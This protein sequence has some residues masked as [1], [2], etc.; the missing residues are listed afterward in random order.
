MKNRPVW[1]FLLLAYAISWGLNEIG[2]Q[3]L[4]EGTVWGS[5]L[6]G[7]VFMWGPAVAVFIL[8]PRLA[9]TWKEL[10]VVK[11][12][13]HW[14]W[15]GVAALLAMA[16]P[17][18]TLLFNWLLGDLLGLPGFGHTAVTK[19]M[20]L[21]IMEDRLAAT[22]WTPDRIQNG[23]DPLASLPLNGP[24][25]LLLA[26]LTGVLAGGTVNLAAAFGEELGW[27]GL[28]LH[29][30]RR[31]GLWAHVLFTGG[32][33]GLWHAPLILRGHNYPDHPVAGVFFMCLFTTALALPMAWV[34]IRSG[35][36]WAPA[37]MHGTVNGVAG[38]VTLFH[39]G[40]SELLGGAVGTSAVLAL[41][42]IG[43]GLFLFDP[44][45]RREFVA[46]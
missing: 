43:A 22:G 8:R 27:R 17:V 14:K 12:G 16:W 38:T 37:L 25:I 29:L 46:A 21:G 26:L 10:G 23:L 9:V 7:L 36:V 42:T 3:V 4:G 28:L 11:N 31:W 2:R 34:H 32:V 24:L 44:Q 15:V 13:I 33:W 30:T 39:S 41:M 19:A 6:F 45:F 1:S 35:C 20:M 40:S 18:I 5:L